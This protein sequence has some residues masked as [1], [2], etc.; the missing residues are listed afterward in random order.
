M[1]KKKQES[2]PVQLARKSILH[3]LETGKTIN[4][5][6]G[7]PKEFTEKKAGTFVSLKKDGKLRGCIGTFLATRNNIALEIIENA[8]SAAVHDPRFSPL[9]LEEV[10]FLDISVDILTPPEE[11][12]DISQ[13]N[14]K[15]YG[16]IVSTGYRK[17]LLLPDLDG[18]DT[19]EY[20]IDI[21]RQKAGI[22]PDEKYQIQRFEVIRY[23]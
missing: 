4:Q 18:V 15:K 6:E 7:L 11:V 20:Q 13:L 8:I 10:D 2:I 22:S 5:T 21:A 23:Y 14:P 19:V 12:D 17:G 1:M 16:V 3:Y 9:K